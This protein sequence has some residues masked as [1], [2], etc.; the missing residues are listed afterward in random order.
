MN[1]NVTSHLKKPVKVRQ[2]RPKYGMKNAAIRRS[3]ASDAGG[4]YEKPDM[5][6]R[7]KIGGILV[8]DDM[9]RE[10]SRIVISKLITDQN[11]RKPARP[12]R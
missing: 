6:K 11:T 10:A 3:S 8:V 5:K 2:R 1:N 7:E 9:S 4:A 12:K